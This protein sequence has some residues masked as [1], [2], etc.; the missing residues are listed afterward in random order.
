[1]KA[2]DITLVGLLVAILIVCSQIAIPIGPVPI[3]LQTFAVML[4]GMIVK[5]KHAFY[6]TLLYLIIGVFGLPVFAGG[7]GGLQAVL[8]PSFGFVIGFIP[9]SLLQS[10]YLERNLLNGNKEL[11]I[12]AAINYIVSYLIGMTYMFFIL[13]VYL[14][15]AFSIPQILMIGLVPFIPG[16]LLKNILA[17]TVGKRLRPQLKI[18]G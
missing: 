5:P 12:A 8:S 10:Y 7:L 1:M 18:A 9:A 6:T 3:T 14:H 4:I 15:S 13:N 11:I 16:D 17:I 2:K